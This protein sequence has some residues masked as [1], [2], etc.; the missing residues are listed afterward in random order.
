MNPVL[1]SIELAS[2]STLAGFYRSG[3]R[4]FMEHRWGERVL[5]RAAV[6]LHCANWDAAGYIKD[7]S[8]SGAFVHTRL[9]IPTWTHIELNLSGT[10]VAAFVVRVTA[11]GFGIEW[12]EFGPPAVR[13]L[14]A[15]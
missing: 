12:C 11:E 15:R 8:L 3:H 2:G 14:L 5:V 9:Q 1:E 6:R 13:E 7:A 4:A 10:R